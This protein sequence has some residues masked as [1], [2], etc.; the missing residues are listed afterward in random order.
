MEW[1]KDKNGK[2]Y[3][4]DERG[5]RRLLQ[6]ENGQVT[7]DNKLALVLVF[8]VPDPVGSGKL[9]QGPTIPV[10]L[11]QTGNATVVHNAP[12]E[13]VFQEKLE[14]LYKYM[15]GVDSG[16][17]PVGFAKLVRDF[18]GER[19]MNKRA[20]LSSYILEQ[21]QD[22]AEKINR[23]EPLGLSFPERWE[24]GKSPKEKTESV[25]KPR[26][27]VIN[28]LGGPGCGKSTAMAGVFNEMKILGVNAEECSEWIKE[29]VYDGD[30]YPFQNQIFTFAQQ[31][32]RQD[33][34]DGKVDYIVTDSPLLLS[35]FYG[36]DKYSRNELS[37][38]VLSE[39]RRFNNLNIF[40]ERPK[41]FQKEGRVHDEAQSDA[42]DNRI[43]D[44]LGK[45]GIPFVSVKADKDIVK[46][47]LAV[48][49]EHNKDAR[50]LGDRKVIVNDGE[51][52]H[53]K[54]FS[55]RVTVEPVTLG[56]RDTLCVCVQFT[57]IGRMDGAKVFIPGCMMT[58]SKEKGKKVLHFGKDAKCF[59]FRNGKDTGIVMDASDCGRALYEDQKGREA[60]Y[61][62]AGPDRPAGL[63]R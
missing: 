25:K 54:V 6:I 2:S 41:T 53:R 8:N 58:N 14:S 44:Y 4:Y 30:S 40:I 33:A 34:M 9:L 55:E 23:K 59:V 7:K 5:Q 26:T 3:F 39:F 49:A 21:V 60:L 46:N 27:L 18:T 16:D 32:K 35:A 45:H 47:I 61:G 13:L 19:D 48:V 38:L 10:L 12:S 50:L 36:D 52:L 1:W 24:Q 57:K 11:S 28:L 43:K 15:L 37:Q 63:G 20:M 51:K 56:G 22:V 42:I 31:D 29:K 62:K 17:E